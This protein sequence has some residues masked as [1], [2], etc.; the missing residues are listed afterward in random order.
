MS[1][2]GIKHSRQS[3]PLDGPCVICSKNTLDSENVRLLRNLG[4][5]E[6][7]TGILVSPNSAPAWLTPKYLNGVKLPEHALLVT[8]G[9]ETVLEGG[10][11]VDVGVVGAG[12]EEVI[13]W[14]APG[15]HW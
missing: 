15:W 8:V 2:P 13:V 5:G 9:P 10:L 14:L 7:H 12:V 11:V 4:K 6:P 1:S 3:S